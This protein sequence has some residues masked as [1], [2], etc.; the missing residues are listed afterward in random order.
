MTEVSTECERACTQHLLIQAGPSFIVLTGKLKLA[1]RF[2]KA[3]NIA[4]EE[5][6]V[7]LKMKDAS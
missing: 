3:R 5:M 1:L 6:M 2:R 4:W 7:L